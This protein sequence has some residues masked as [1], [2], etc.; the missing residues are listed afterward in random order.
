MVE[1]N[2]MGGGVRKQ[3][4]RTELTKRKPREKRKNKSNKRLG[5][6]NNR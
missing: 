6:W 3:T 5:R 4:R 1:E 2:K